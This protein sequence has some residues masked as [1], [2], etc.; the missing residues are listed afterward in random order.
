MTEWIVVLCRTQARIFSRNTLK[1][2]LRPLHTI[3]NPLGRERNRNMQYDRAGTD[4]LR[5]R[6]ARVPHSMS[7]EKDPHEDATLQFVRQIADH[8]DDAKKRN[9]FGRLTVIAD[10][11]ITGHLKGQLAQPATIEWVQKNLSKLSDHEINLAFLPNGDAFRPT[12][13]RDVTSDTESEVKIPFTISFRDVPQSD[14]V[15]LDVQSRVEKL[16]RF[17]FR[18]M[19]CEVIIASPHNHKQKGR[20]YHVEIRLHIPGEDIYICRE[21]AKNDAH[22]DIYIAIKDAFKTLERKLASQRN[23]MRGFVKHHEN[24]RRTRPTEGPTEEQFE[25]Y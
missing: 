12:T 25:N 6:G 11:H 14:S 24:V 2:P 4:S 1:D 20:V 5:L 21:P 7:G 9:D 13:P 8:L 22:S 3:E 19:S 15:W 17:N 23:R 18:I 10:S 16:A